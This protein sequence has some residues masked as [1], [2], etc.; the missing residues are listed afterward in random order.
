MLNHIQT[1]DGTYKRVNIYQNDF[2]EYVLRCF[3]DGIHIREWNYHTLTEAEA[4]NEANAFLN[5]YQEEK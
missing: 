2:Q 3:K 1:I 5:T 4:I